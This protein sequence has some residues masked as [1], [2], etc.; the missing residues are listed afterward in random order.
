MTPY[1]A[2]RY[3]WFLLIAFRIDIFHSLCPL[4]F[5]LFLMPTRKPL[6]MTIRHDW[7]AVDWRRCEQQLNA[8]E[9]FHANRFGEGF[10]ARAAGATVESSFTP[11]GVKEWSQ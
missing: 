8:G 2:Q 4:G 7:R 1:T 6:N 3:R 9:A 10:V 5:N 11:G